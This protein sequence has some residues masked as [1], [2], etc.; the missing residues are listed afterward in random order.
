MVTLRQEKSA[1]LKLQILEAAINL[2]G[3]NSFEELYVDM[4]CERVKVSKV[5]LFKYFPQK[6]DI[7]LYYLRVWLLHR[8]VEL[9]KTDY[10]GLAGLRLVQ[11]KLCES[12]MNHPGV[13]L[14]LISYLTSLKRPPGPVSLKMA[15]R[16]Q[17]YSAEELED[18]EIR[19]LH[20]L[21]ENFVLEAIFNAEIT[22][23]SDTKEI[24]NLFLSVMYGTLVTAHLNQIAPIKIYMKRNLDLALEALR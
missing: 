23:R 5:T 1:R 15:E 4:I 24:A 6:D 22:K 19:S 9:S 13:I 21:V 20:Q 12:F 16:I 3:K 18:V 8:A 11:D 2:V 14:G 7:L 10:I 17:L